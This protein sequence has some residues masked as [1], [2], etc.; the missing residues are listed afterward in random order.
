MRVQYDP[1]ERTLSPTLSS[2]GV[3]EGEDISPSA[4]SGCSADDFRATGGLFATGVALLGACHRGSVRG[5]TANS[6]TSVSLEPLL[7]LCC[8]KEGAPMGQLVQAAGCFGISV[9]SHAQ[10]HLARRFADPRRPDGAA[11]FRD[12]AWY[13]G[14]APARRC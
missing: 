11:Q 9:L 10:E 14:P 8:L 12:V 5:M 3:S 1:T 7:L 4:H 2:A 6:L 13:P